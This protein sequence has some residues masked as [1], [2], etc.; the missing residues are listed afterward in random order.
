ME[1]LSYPGRIETRGFNPVTLRP[2]LASTQ[3]CRLCA[4]FLLPTIMTKWPAFPGRGT[5]F[6]GIEL[7][8]GLL[9]YGADG[10]E[11]YVH[12][13]SEVGTVASGAFCRAGRQQMVVAADAVVVIH[14]AN[15][16]R[17][18]KEVAGGPF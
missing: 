17:G 7:F 16:R 11:D 15:C 3:S 6:A 8:R 5:R 4:S 14:E 10:T 9:L 18:I 2:R 1:S 12:V 13:G